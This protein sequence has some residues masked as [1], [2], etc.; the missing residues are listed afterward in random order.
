MQ[1]QNKKDKAKNNESWK[2]IHLEYLKLQSV[3]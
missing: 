2:Q 3:V 1:C